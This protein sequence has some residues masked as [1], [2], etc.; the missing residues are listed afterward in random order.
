LN[1]IALG[2]FPILAKPGV[3]R[4]F[5]SKPCCGWFEPEHS[6]ENC[7]FAH[8]LMPVFCIGQPLPMVVGQAT[9]VQPIAADFY[10]DEC[11]LC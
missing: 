4:A 5:A 10:A 9:K 1:R 3:T 6:G 11:S 2:G 8:A 7:Q